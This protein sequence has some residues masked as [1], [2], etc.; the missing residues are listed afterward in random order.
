MVLG[1]T[2]V[3]TVGREQS[4]VVFDDWV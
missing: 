1:R 4:T 3:L 2:V